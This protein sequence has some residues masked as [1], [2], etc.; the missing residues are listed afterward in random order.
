MSKCT[1]RFIRSSEGEGV[2]GD[3]VLTI[4]DDDLYADLLR[5]RFSPCELKTTQN[6]VY[7]DREGAIEYLSTILRTLPYDADPF[8]LLQVETAIHPTVLYHVSDLKDRSL[9][10]LIEDTV[11]NALRRTIDN[12]RRSK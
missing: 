9:R 1:F 2:K 5:V 11:S 4:M 6:V 3:D 12:V 8:E 7:L 10:Y